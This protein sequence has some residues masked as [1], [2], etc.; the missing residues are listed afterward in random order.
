MT[1]I[2]L[3]LAFCFF[4]FNCFSAEESFKIVVLGSGGGPLESNLSGYLIAPK[5][6][7]DFV[8]LDAGALLNGIGIAEKNKC[9]EEIQ[10]DAES[11]FCKE[12]QI[13]RDHIKAY[14]ISHAHLDHIM[15]LVIASTED[16][17]KPIFG[18]NSV[19]NFLRDYIFNGKIWPNFGSE[20]N[21]PQINQYAYQRLAFEKCIPIP[22]TK[23]K[24]ET[25]LLSHP[26]GYES[27]AFL[28]ESSGCYVVYFGD[29]APDCLE[30]KKH[31]DKVW[32]RLA[33]LV[34]EKKLKGVFLECS[35][36]DKPDNQLFGHLD[37][38]HMI[39][40]LRHFAL[41]V[42]PLNPESALKDLKVLV[43]HIKDP[44]LQRDFYKQ[45]IAE[46]LEKLNDLGIQFI[47]PSQ[48]EKIEI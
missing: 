48:G 26:G 11:S 22:H 27:S 24:V 19:I 8:C 42:D 17:P 35:Y 36:L 3:A 34:L 40:E 23:M 33:P 39:D 15:G 44:C 30:P 4:Y 20:G 45:Q 5:D 28:I 16:S 37:A 1:K 9:F 7:T 29:T 6:S 12:R 41:L 25:Y 14:L 46:E 38:K 21:F 13:L 2:S 47:F 43:I 32:K 18:I 10:W 31:M